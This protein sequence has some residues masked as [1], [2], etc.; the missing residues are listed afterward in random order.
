MMLKEIKNVNRKESVKY[1]V[2]HGNTKVLDE[3]QE[4]HVSLHM[5][6]RNRSD[7]FVRTFFGN[8][9]N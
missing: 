9:I 1:F 4:R 7:E 8:R 2:L 3:V 6:S 5:C